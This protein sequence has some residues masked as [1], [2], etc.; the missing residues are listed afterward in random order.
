MAELKMPPPGKVIIGVIT[1]D[2]AVMGSAQTLLEKELGPVENKS[3]II[4]FD[5]TDYYE[6]EMGKNLLRLWL[7]FA[8]PVFPDKL[9]EIKLKTIEL[10]KKFF[11]ANGN[12][13]INLDPGMLTLSNLILA[14]TKNYYHRIYLGQGIYAEVTLVYRHNNFEPLVWTYPDYRTDTA[15][16][17]FMTARKAL[18]NAN[19]VGEESLATDSQP[20]K[21]KPPKKEATRASRGIKR[22]ENK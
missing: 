13:T 1:C 9:R 14:T 16:S 4:D 12:R 7:S 2:L 15:L 19:L 20:V 6:V 5:F 8:Q 11:D 21:S 3:P 10:E 22:K 17:F 18:L